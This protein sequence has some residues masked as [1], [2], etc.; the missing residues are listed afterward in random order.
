MYIYIIQTMINSN[1]T[2]ATS[3]LTDWH[4]AGDEWRQQT[5]LLVAIVGEYLVIHLP[6]GI[7]PKTSSGANYGSYTEL[8][9]PET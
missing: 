6:K 2:A 4:S 7:K 5:A 3:D 8:T 1:H 9:V